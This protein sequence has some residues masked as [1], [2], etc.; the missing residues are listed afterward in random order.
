MF[1]RNGC[2]GCLKNGLKMGARCGLLGLR[3]RW[4]V[5]I[6]FYPARIFQPYTVSAK[7]D[8]V[9]KA[10]L[11]LALHPPSVSAKFDGMKKACLA[12]ALHPPSVST[13]SDGI[14]DKRVLNSHHR[15][16]APAES[17]GAPAKNAQIRY[18]QVRPSS[19]SDGALAIKHS[20]LL[21]P[22][23]AS[24]QIRWRASDSPV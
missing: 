6:S 12:L 1:A 13:N 4:L 9:K 20:N 24:I 23:L 17:D 16:S 11:A 21:H 7:F 8:G 10:C 2:S 5:V 22:S 14:P 15:F 3:G 18:I 19:I